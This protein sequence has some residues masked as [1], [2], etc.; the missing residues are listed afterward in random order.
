MEGFEDFDSVRAIMD[1]TYAIQHLEIALRLCEK[2]KKICASSDSVWRIRN[3]IIYERGRY[4][5]KLRNKDMKNFFKNEKHEIK[6][7]IVQLN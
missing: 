6:S 5:E 3:H 1:I 2:H 7:D 4:I